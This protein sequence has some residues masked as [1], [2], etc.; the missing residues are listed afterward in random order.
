V[1]VNPHK[2]KP[3]LD[4]INREANYN[5]PKLENPSRR[6]KNWLQPLIILVGR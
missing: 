6:R 2:I 1:L 3:P 4:A 5:V